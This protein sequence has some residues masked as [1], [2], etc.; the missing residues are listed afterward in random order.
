M[1]PKKIADISSDVIE[2]LNGLKSYS[3]L[4][5]YE[6]IVILKVTANVLT[7]MNSHIA[8]GQMIQAQINKFNDE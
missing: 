2:M 1:N 5:S 7:E 6:Q 3:S 4:T 8:I